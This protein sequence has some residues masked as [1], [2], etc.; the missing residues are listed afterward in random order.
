M[1]GLLLKGHYTLSSTESDKPGVVSP[2][3][4]CRLFKFPMVVL[5]GKYH[6]ALMPV[7]HAVWVLQY[8]RTFALANQPKVCI[9]LLKC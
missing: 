6:H 8:V 7:D 9:S 3:V 4:L 5:L 1:E 2:K